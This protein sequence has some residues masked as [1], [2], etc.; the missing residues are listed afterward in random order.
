MWAQ[1][2]HNCIFVLACIYTIH[3]V[4]NQIYELHVNSKIIIV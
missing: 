1:Y 2:P 4:T 3:K